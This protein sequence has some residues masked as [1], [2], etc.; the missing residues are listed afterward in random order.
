MNPTQHKKPFVATHQRRGDGLSAMLLGS[1]GGHSLYRV[2]W[3]DN[4][5]RYEN[6][7]R[8][9][10]SVFAKMFLPLSSAGRAA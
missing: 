5:K 2:Q 1:H 6:T 3:F 7:L 10:D 9:P 8:R 4:G